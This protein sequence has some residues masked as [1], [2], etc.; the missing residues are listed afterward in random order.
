MDVRGVQLSREWIDPPDPLRMRMPAL[1]NERSLFSEGVC[2]A[3]SLLGMWTA[4]A[5][6]VCMLMRDRYACRTTGTCEC[7]PASQVDA[8]HSIYILMISGIPSPPHARGVC[9]TPATLSLPVAD[10]P[11]D[12]IRYVSGPFKI[13]AMPRHDH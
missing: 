5:G 7:A 6:D 2:R 11:E 8:M 1:F 13:R 12:N 9:I 4:D 10:V 3:D